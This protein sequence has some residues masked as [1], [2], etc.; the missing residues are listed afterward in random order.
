ME[1]FNVG[2]S[3][4]LSAHEDYHKGTPATPTMN[5]AIITDLVAAASALAAGQVDY[6]EEMTPDAFEAV[7]SAENV[8]VAEYPRLPPPRGAVQRP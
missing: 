2:Q 3:V 6:V 5:F 1:E 7:R 8:K 4:V